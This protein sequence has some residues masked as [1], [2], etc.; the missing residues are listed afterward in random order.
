MQYDGLS[1]GQRARR[2]GLFAASRSL[3]MRLVMSVGITTCGAVFLS[4]CGA[5][6]LRLNLIV[7]SEAN[8]N[9]P[10]TISAVFVY[11]GKLLPKL[12]EMTAAQWFQKREQ[13]LRD[14]P[15]DIEEVYW[16]FIP[17]QQVPKVER[18]LKK[19]ALQGILF[20]NYRSPGAHRYLFD[21]KRAQEWICGSREIK[22]QQ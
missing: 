14:Y 21:P 19:S 7:E 9:S 10:V 5:D 16:E 2:C 4:G 8:T 11:S 20:A 22:L 6:T 18:P 13:F 3:L 15:K 17:G 1:R 12:E